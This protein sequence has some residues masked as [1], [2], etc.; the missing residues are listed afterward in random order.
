ML[1]PI[2]SRILL[3]MLNPRPV[4]RSLLFWWSSNRLK[5]RNNF[6][7]FSLAIPTPESLIL[8]SN[9]MYF[10]SPF[11]PTVDTLRFSFI[12]SSYRTLGVKHLLAVIISKSFLIYFML[13]LFQLL[14]LEYCP[15]SL[16]VPKP[17]PAPPPSFSW[18]LSRVLIS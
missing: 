9:L 1:P 15:V 8:I 17:V 2:F 16:P 18:L 11:S 12:L 13:L 6:D 3:Q 10:L 14:S 7:K 4:P 5:F